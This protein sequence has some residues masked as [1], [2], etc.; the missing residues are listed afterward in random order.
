M[1]RELTIRLARR[2]GGISEPEDTLYMF[3][4]SMVLVPFAMLLYG[5]GVTYHV[6]V[7]CETDILD[8]DLY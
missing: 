6:Y 8:R 3:I 7:F 2:R 5:L 1:G 4:A